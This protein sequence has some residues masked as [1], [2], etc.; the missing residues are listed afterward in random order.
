MTPK[1]YLVNRF[2]VGPYYIVVGTV[3]V[4]YA[5][6]VLYSFCIKALYP[7]SYVQVK[8]IVVRNIFN[9]DSLAKFFFFGLKERYTA[10]PALLKVNLSLTFSLG[11]IDD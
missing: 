4:V 5:V 1:R 9:S 2:K 6:I 3:D 10:F 7:Q 11:N 8:N